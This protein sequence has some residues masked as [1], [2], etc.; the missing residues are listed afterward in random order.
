M[1]FRA[2]HLYGGMLHQE[3][4]YFIG[5]VSRVASHTFLMILSEDE[6]LQSSQM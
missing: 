6:I 4:R 1:V 3:D 5:S 2:K